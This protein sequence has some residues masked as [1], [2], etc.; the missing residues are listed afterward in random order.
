MYEREQGGGAASVFESLEKAGGEPVVLR[1]QKEVWVQ[2]ARFV[3]RSSHRVLQVPLRRCLRGLIGAVRWEWGGSFWL[4]WERGGKEGWVGW[5]KGA[6][7]RRG[8]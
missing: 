3:L 4:A 1:L 2:A 7:S 5:H 8:K 6:E